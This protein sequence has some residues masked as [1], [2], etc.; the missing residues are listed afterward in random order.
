MSVYADLSTT[1]TQALVSKGK[2]YLPN[3][4]WLNVNFPKV[5]A[6]CSSPS[7]FKFVL[8]RV[9]NAFP[10]VTPPDTTTCHNGGRL[11]TESEVVGTA[12]CY[13]S[14]SV[15]DAS[16]KTTAGAAQQKIVLKRL[17]SI[18]SCLP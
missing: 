6:N 16:D 4:V 1:V 17:R 9:N 2:P 7:D 3:N 10:I 18:L 14:V 11:P 12:G 5:D 13:A 8:S 15:A